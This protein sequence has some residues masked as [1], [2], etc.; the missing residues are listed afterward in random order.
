MATSPITAAGAGRPDPRAAGAR[1]GELFEEHGRMVFALCRLIVR[2]REEAE[3]ATQQTFLLVH[4]SMLNGVVPEQPAAWVAAIARNECY[5][6]LGRRPPDAVALLDSDGGGDDPAGV[7]DQRA[8]IEA[9]CQALAELPRGQ[10]EAVVLREFYGLSYRQVAAALELSGPAVESLLFKSRRRLQERLRPIHAAASVLMLPPAIRDVLAAAIPGFSGAAAGS[11]GATAAGSV[12]ATA[13]GAVIAKVGSAPLAAKLATALLV[14]GTGT[15]VTVGETRHGGPAPSRTAAVVPKAEPQG[16]SDQPARVSGGGFR[17]RSAPL[18]L[19]VDRR[20]DDGA[21]A[22]A[23]KR[24]AGAADDE[25]RH[26]DAEREPVDVEREPVDGEREEAD[27]DEPATE[28][29]ERAQAR[30]LEQRDAGEEEDRE[31]REV[32]DPQD[33]GATEERDEV[34]APEVDDPPAEDHE[35]DVE[36]E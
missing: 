18:V 20:R 28:E 33:D 1:V 3:D 32:T 34:E 25:G 19:A 12:G 31:L 22:D 35:V 16:A 13:A 4:R 15:A 6:R 29:H 26:A 9:L 21:G 5:R 11:A 7:V 23:G 36:D 24:D 8:E 17:L 2:E 10:R 14:V 27:R 30:E